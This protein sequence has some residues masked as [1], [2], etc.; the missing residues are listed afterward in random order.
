MEVFSLSFLKLVM[1]GYGQMFLANNITSG[2][3]FFLGLLILSPVNAVWSLLGAVASTLLAKMSGMK[4][5]MESGLFGVNGALL[6]LSWLMFPEVPAIG[7]LILTLFGSL[8]IVALLFSSI[9]L[10]KRMRIGL[11]LFALPY[12]FAVWLNVLIASTAG[13][14]EPIDLRGWNALAMR[15]PENAKILFEESSPKSI[16]GRWYQH[17]GLGWANYYLAD[18]QTALEKFQKSIEL[19]PTLFD[20]YSGAGWSEF[21]LGHYE[22]AQLFFK[23]ANTWNGLG[24]IHL[25]K[26]EYQEARSYFIKCILST[27]LNSD[28]YLGL[29]RIAFQTESAKYSSWLTEISSWIGKNISPIMQS[30]SSIQILTWMLFLTGILW[31]SRTSFL[32]TF[33][34]ITI[35]LAL[36]WMVPSIG[37]S[38]SDINLFINLL[39]LL[40][41]FGGQYL[42][43][44]LKTSLWTA[45]LAIGMV[46]TWEWFGSIFN[47]VGLPVLCLPFNLAL[48]GTLIVFPWFRLT[49]GMLIPL[50][51]ATSSPEEVNLWL[52]KAQ[53]VGR[54][55]QKLIEPVR[56][57]KS[58][59]QP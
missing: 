26:G 46:A 7:K 59:L 8:I 13:W 1:R 48:V 9:K 55:W 28:A 57:N 49:R 51:V 18:Y 36:T 5:E 39:A 33:L 11:T 44:G 22:Q 31:H 40:L 50:E 38:F 16:R 2:M 42:R 25:G 47:L 29:S 14:Y 4:R 30:V 45:F 56:I 19:E 21:N 32:I 23:T 12:I 37:R 52:A 53:L 3:I 6:G 10:F 35:L 43:I 54:C 27:P 41:A 20:A 58:G 17:D 15:K 24:W 34:M